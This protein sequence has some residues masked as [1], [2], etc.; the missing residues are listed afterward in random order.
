MLVNRSYVS[1]HYNHNTYLDTEIY[2]KKR[3]ARNSAAS[4]LIR[5]QV[6]SSAIN[7]A[8]WRSHIG[9]STWRGVRINAVCVPDSD[10]HS[11][12]CF[13]PVPVTASGLPRNPLTDAQIK[14]VYRVAPQNTNIASGLSQGLEETFRDAINSGKN[15]RLHY[16]PHGFQRFHSQSAS[17]QLCL[18][19]PLTYFIYLV[20]FPLL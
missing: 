17:I 16:T 5:V 10:A 14:M 15:W 4:G 19:L 11:S 6:T 20:G 12:D 18:F 7:R 8:G 2:S 3:W 1:S 13:T 9:V